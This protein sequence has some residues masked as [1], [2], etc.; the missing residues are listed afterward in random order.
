MDPQSR[1]SPHDGRQG[2][3]HHSDAGGAQTAPSATATASPSLTLGMT[4]PAGACVGVSA[5]GGGDALLAGRVGSDVLTL[6]MLDRIVSTPVETQLSAARPGRH[7][8]PHEQAHAGPSTP[9]RR[10]APPATPWAAP[11]SAQASP[12]RTPSPPDSCRPTPTA[13]PALTPR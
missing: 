8:Q 9:P 10:S 7:R 4:R 13:R 2:L 5:L 1:R 12:V 11:G 3:I 6:A